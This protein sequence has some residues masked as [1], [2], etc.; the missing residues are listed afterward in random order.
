MKN[1]TKIEIVYK[2]SNKTYILSG[3]L[4]SSPAGLSSHFGSLWNTADTL[5]MRLKLTLL[6]NIR[7]LF[8]TITS[9]MLTQ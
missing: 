2:M 5:Y 7:L 8:H 6:Q 3:A 1:D 9:A 4:M